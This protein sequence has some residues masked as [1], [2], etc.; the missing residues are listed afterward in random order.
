M[1]EFVRYRNSQPSP[2]T[3]QRIESSEQKHPDYP[4][5]SIIIPTVD[6]YRGGCFQTLLEQFKE[7]TFQ[8][9]E[10]IIVKG[11]NRQGR[12][13]NIAVSIAKGKYILIL[14][15]DSSLGNEFVFEKL[16]ETLDKNPDIGMAGV[17]NV[18]PSDATWFIKKT[19]KEIPRKSK[20][21]VNR[22]TDSDLAEHGCCIVR[23]GLFKKIGGENE[24]I[25]RGLDPYLRSKIRGKGYRIV[26]I[27]GT[28]YHHLPPD[29]LLKLLLQMFRNGKQ[30]AYCN[31]FYPQWVIE[32]PDYHGADFQE[33]VTFSFRL[34]RYAFRMLKGVIQLKWIY[35][36]AKVCYAIGFVWGYLSLNKRD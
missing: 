4:Y 17:P 23:K 29:N 6:A 34:V 9:Y 14:D 10:I 13:I 5:V 18:I 7:Q 3:I 28:W 11:D 30:A 20:S 8:N 19:M 1:R 22:I 16:V 25:P 26:L 33:K 35:L 32:T 21:P 24:L 2:A 15:D 31:K 12:A 36:L 27:P